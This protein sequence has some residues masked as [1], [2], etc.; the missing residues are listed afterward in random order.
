[1]SL[2]VFSEIRGKGLLIGA[3]LRPQWH[4]KGKDFLAAATKEGLMLLVAGPNVLRMAPSLIIPDDDHSRG[5]ESL[6]SSRRNRPWPVSKW[7]H[8]TMPRRRGIVCI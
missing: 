5:H 4:G 6:K 1:M 3:E 8:Q 7:F 2:G